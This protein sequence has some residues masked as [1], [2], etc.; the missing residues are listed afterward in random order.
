MNTSSVGNIPGNGANIFATRPSGYGDNPF[1][2]LLIA[3]MRSQSPLEPVD[4]ESFMSQMSQLSSMEQQKELNDN[5][6]HLLQFQGA[7]ARLNGLTQ[8]AGM[9]GHEVEYVAD[10]EGTKRSGVVDSVR[11]TEEGE[12]RLRIGKDDV[13]LSAVIAVRGAP[14]DATNHDKRDESNQD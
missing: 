11:V 10:A 13:P 8:G 14:S 5:L 3:Q 7:L 2:Q 6:L 1:L 4:N 12:V 9:I